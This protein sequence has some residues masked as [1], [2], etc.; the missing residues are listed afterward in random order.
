MKKR[1]VAL[2]MALALTASFSTACIGKFATTGKVREFNLE[3][4]QERWPRWGLFL[5][6]YIIPVYP[7]ASMIDLLIVNSIEFWT[8]ENPVSHEPAVTPGA[9]QDDLG[10]NQKSFTAEDGTLVTMTHELDDTVTAVLT[11]PD[12]ETRKLV[13]SKNE[14]G[15]FVEDE[16]GTILMD[17]AARFVSPEL[18]EIL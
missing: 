11:S 9:A 1:L 17:T 2:T 7:F 18:S 13:I 8:G 6:L 10:A 12:G 15:I 5:L 16:Q 3:T 4:T 14:T